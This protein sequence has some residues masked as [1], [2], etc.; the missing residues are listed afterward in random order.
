MMVRSGLYHYERRK[1]RLSVTFNHDP[2]TPLYIQIAEFLEKQI[3]SGAYPLGTRLPSER[4]LAEQYSLSRMTA[5]QALKELTRAG[6]AESVVGKGTFVSQPKIDQQLRELTSFSEDMRMRGLRPT[7]RVLLAEE[8][9]ADDTVA[10]AL[11]LLPGQKIIVLSRVRS[12]DDR[13]VVI[14]TGYLNQQ[15]CPGILDKHDFS[16]E[17]L[18]DVLRLN[19]GIRL[20]WATQGIEA[21]LPSKFER[22]TLEISAN[23][24]VLALTRVTYNEEDVPI[25]YVVSAYCGS[26]YQFRT[27]LW[28][29]GQTKET[30]R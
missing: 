19:Y 9:A 7:S 26:R 21:R 1:L 5:R 22:E 14:E 18:Y 27:I 6:F 17:S 28:R 15:L 11:R 30:K 10:D 29:G 23:E 8:T 4:E 13:P 16:H 12:A 3:R 2:K 24:P 25:E 20:V